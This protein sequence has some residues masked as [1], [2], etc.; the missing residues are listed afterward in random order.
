MC[1]NLLRSV[2]MAHRITV[3]TDMYLQKSLSLQRGMVAGIQAERIKIYCSRLTP[4]V[5][6]F[7]YFEW[8]LIFYKR[9]SDTQSINAT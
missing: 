5:C 3:Q 9:K 2:F 6:K 8:N 7:I 1:I 4:S